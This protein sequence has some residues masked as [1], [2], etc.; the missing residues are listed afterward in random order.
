MQGKLD[1]QSVSNPEAEQ[2][3]RIVIL[4]HIRYDSRWA[5]HLSPKENL[6]DHPR[7]TATKV[8]RSMRLTVLSL[9]PQRHVDVPYP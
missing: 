9:S 6:S 5:L 8:T 1:L 2:R 4:V 7:G 3:A